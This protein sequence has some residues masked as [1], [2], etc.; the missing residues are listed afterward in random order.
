MSGQELR[1]VPYNGNRAYKYYLDGYKVNGKR[2]RLFFKDVAAANRKLAELAKRQKKEGQDGLDIPLELRVMAVKATQRLAPFDKNVLDAAEF[3]AAHLERESGSILVSDAIEDYLGSKVRA[4]LSQRHLRDIRGRIGRFNKA[5]G[6]RLIRTV[7]V[8]EI[9]DWLHGLSLGPQSVV[10]YR[11]VVHALFEHCVKRLLVERNPIAA[12]DKVKLVDKAP[13][14]LTPEQLFKLLS[15]APFDL[16]PVLAIQAFAGLRTEEMMRLDWSEVDQVR[17]YITVSAKKAKTARRR[18][19]P[20]AN[21]LA[22]WLRPYTEMSGL[23]WPKGGRFYHKAINRLLSDIGMTHWPQNAL[24]HS[25]A[26]YHLAKHCNASELMLYMG[27]TSTKQIF[28]AYRELVHP[29]TAEVYWNLAPPQVESTVR[30]PITKR[31]VDNHP[32][33]G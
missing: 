7:A 5:F 18:L 16:L 1:I 29:Q 11:A 3:Y 8:R 21:N 20:I 2:K 26:S 30:F 19:I 15:A 10:N 17:G 9:E 33:N 23:L 28:A 24:R 32:L 6:L 12:I 25:F 27:H 14:I 4:G 31:V 22:Q 13:E